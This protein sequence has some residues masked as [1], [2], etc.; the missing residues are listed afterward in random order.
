MNL[1]DFNN[2]ISEDV[3]Q[4]E[5]LKVPPI[6]NAN[7]K[8]FLSTI[9]ASNSVVSVFKATDNVASFYDKCK[10]ADAIEIGED[11]APTATERRAALIEIF[12]AAKLGY[13]LKGVPSRLVYILHKAKEMGWTPYVNRQLER[14]LPLIQTYAEK[15]FEGTEKYNVQDVINSEWRI[16]AN[17]LTNVNFKIEYE[18]GW[19]VWLPKVER[20][21]V[22][23]KDM[24]E[25]LSFKDCERIEYDTRN[26]LT[27]DGTPLRVLGAR[28]GVTKDDFDLR[29]CF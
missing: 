24:G 7:V 6:T 23:P 2:R 11:V 15:Y 18:D 9:A 1:A 21:A 28:I 26:G 27:L 19:E 17:L 20:V 3:D 14:V 8:T 5:L 4:L 16:N 25:M 12:Y 13:Y 29:E 10:V 22:L